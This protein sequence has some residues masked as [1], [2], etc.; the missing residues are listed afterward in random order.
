MKRFYFCIAILFLFVT[1]SCQ[2]EIEY[3]TPED[4]LTGKFWYL[5][6]KT[7]GQQSYNYSGATTFSFL[8]TKSTKAYRDS[9]GIEGNYTISEQLPT[10]ELRIQSG[11]RQIDAYLVSLLEKDQIVLTY[12][13]NNLLHTF[14]FSTRR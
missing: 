4:K 11:N 13:K 8:L 9:D 5:E 6:K 12:T 7:V 2:K 1:Q 10:T 14:Y 3:E